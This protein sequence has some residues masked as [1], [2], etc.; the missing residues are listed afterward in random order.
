MIKETLQQN[1]LNRHNTTVISDPVL[2]PTCHESPTD[3]RDHT[4][5]STV[6]NLNVNVV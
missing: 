5:V 3:R 4:I 2:K 1:I 6:C